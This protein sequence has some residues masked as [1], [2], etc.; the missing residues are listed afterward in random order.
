MP[1]V[2]VII[3]N[4]N[5]APFLVQRIGSVLNQTFQDFEVIILD[6][7][8]PDNSR[9]IIEK[10]R[11]HPKV[12]HIE[13]NTVNSGSTFKQWNKG[14]NLAKGEYVWIAESDDWAD[15]R[16]LEVLIKPFFEYENLGISYCNSYQID[17]NGNIIGDFVDF[18]D[19]LDKKRWNDNY[20]NK[21]L[22]EIE[23]YFISKCI[24]INVSSVLFRKNVFNKIGIAHE[25]F[26]LMG[27]WMF[28]LKILQNHDISYISKK[29][30]FFRCHQQNVRSKNNKNL[31]SF[32]STK[33]L[34][35]IINNFNPEISKIKNRLFIVFKENYTSFNYSLTSFDF[36]NINKSLYYFV[37]TNFEIFKIYLKNY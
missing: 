4:Y 23:N 14:I 7:C 28:Y 9:E 6:D 21:G 36:N 17:K 25:N 1:T 31:S 24:I 2:S 12:V 16:F 8:S 32:E 22:N 30:N 33:V 19:S 3:P 34:K 10:Y 26:K 20:F 27:D 35:H 15:E 11:N 18:Y 5:H 37:K 29:L 13:Y